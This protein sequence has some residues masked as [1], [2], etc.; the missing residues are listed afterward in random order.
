MPKNQ[1][2]SKT[3][4]SG[5]PFVPIIITSVVSTV[6]FFIF[7]ALFAL[8]SLKTSFD[9]SLYLP[10][11]VICSALSGFI[12]GFAV[13]RMTK[14]KGMI[15][16]GISG[17]FH[18]LLCSLVIFIMNKGVAGNGIFIL[19]AVAVITASLGGVSSVNIKKK[20]KY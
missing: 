10:V 9:R 13:A 8:F 15:Y 18:S 16:G 14:I 1:R 19:I 5:L 4:K 20:I 12:C 11:A 7:I 2:S 6:L 3:D 17:L